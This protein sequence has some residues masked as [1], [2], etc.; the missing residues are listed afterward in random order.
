MLVDF[1]S[2]KYSLQI[3]FHL[4]DQGKLIITAIFKTMYDK[5]YLYKF[6]YGILENKNSKI[7][8]R[9]NPSLRKV[10]VRNCVTLLYKNTM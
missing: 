9:E 2:K 7:Y 6:F 4:S 8:F 3:N 10:V 1:I 5:I